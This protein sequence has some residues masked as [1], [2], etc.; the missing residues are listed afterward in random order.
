MSK[1]RF[2]VTPMQKHII[3]LA[4]E[5]KDFED[6]TKALA[7]LL[8]LQA[9]EDRAFKEKGR[10][11]DFNIST[12]ALKAAING[13]C[14]MVVTELPEAT[15]YSVVNSDHKLFR[16]LGFSTE[17]FPILIVE[18]EDAKEVSACIIEKFEERAAKLAA[19]PYVQE[20][21]RDR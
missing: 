17:T 2:K 12:D 15:R 20:L 10:P 19:D 18:G 3:E 11:Y 13:G 21:W 14:G 16:E 4:G 9:A 8:G 5:F 7:L 6:Y 1:K